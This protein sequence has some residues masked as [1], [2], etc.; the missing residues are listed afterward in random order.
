[1]KF[2]NV[3]AFAD[4]LAKQFSFADVD[5]TR[6]KAKGYEDVYTDI[7]AI[8]LTHETTKYISIIFEED[9]LDTILLHT[10][11]ASPVVIKHGKE[12]SQLIAVLEYI[13]TKL[14]I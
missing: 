14:D 8:R 10:V 1:M 6:R 7:V 11:D 13:K 9:Q 2:T 5:Y 3:K 12:I 4:D